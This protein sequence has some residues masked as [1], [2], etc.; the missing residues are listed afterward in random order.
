M[1]NYPPTIC[2]SVFLVG[3]LWERLSFELFRDWVCWTKRSSWGVRKKVCVLIPDNSSASSSSAGKLQELNET[4]GVKWQPLG[5]YIKLEDLFFLFRR[6][7]S[8]PTATSIDCHELVRI[9]LCYVNL[10]CTNNS[11][12]K[13]KKK[14]S[15]FLFPFFYFTVWRHSYIIVQ[16]NYNNYPIEMQNKFQKDF[17]KQHVELAL[18]CDAITAFCCSLLV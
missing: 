10:W 3:G 11:H 8:L 12:W 18:A 14:Q 4:A 5:Q 6:F 17:L 1:T 16:I 15:L 2:L 13:S 7:V 9:F